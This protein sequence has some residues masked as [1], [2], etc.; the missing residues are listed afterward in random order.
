LALAASL[1]DEGKRAPRWQRAFRAPREKDDGGADKVFAKTRG[2]INPAILDGYRHEF[3]SLP[4][5]EKNA[6]FEALPEDWRDLVLHLV[7][8]HHGQARP[9]IRTQSCEDAPPSALEER[10]RNV[11]LRFA[12]LQ[13]RWGPWGLAWWEALLRAADQQASRENDAAIQAVVPHMETI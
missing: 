1:H 11:A 3:G 10:A 7:A 5:L 2:P 13:N 6:G 4:Y 8:A 12:R 9:L